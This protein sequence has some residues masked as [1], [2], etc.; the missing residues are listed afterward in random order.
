[1]SGA[2]GSSRG[3]PGKT[4]IQGP[5][6]LPPK[7]AA[8]LSSTGNPPTSGY[9]IGKVVK[10]EGLSHT[11]DRSLEIVKPT[12]RL[13]AGGGLSVQITEE[14]PEA[15]HVAVGGL[16]L[17]SISSEDGKIRPFTV[18]V[19]RGI[20]ASGWFYAPEHLW[21]QSELIKI[22]RPQNVETGWAWMLGKAS[23]N[24][25]DACGWGYYTL[26]PHDYT[27]RLNAFFLPV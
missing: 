2:T 8:T 17:F 3:G 26:L 11:S 5:R 23:G 24:D 9:F 1:M 18:R 15:Q 20:E 22:L 27:G 10:N 6:P 19:T 14:N 16:I 21:V 12:E 7:H 25:L 4:P 13:W